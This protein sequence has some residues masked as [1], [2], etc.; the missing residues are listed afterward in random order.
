VTIEYGSANAADLIEL[1]I[2]PE[3]GLKLILPGTVATGSVNIDGKASTA[4]VINLFG[5]VNRAT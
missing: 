3:D 5:F 1:T 4:D 2:A